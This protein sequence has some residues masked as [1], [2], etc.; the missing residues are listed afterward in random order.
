MNKIKN[1]KLPQKIPFKFE[2]GRIVVNTSII[3]GM[4][5]ATSLLATHASFYSKPFSEFLH[6]LQNNG[7]QEGWSVIAMSATVYLVL[8]LMLIF[9]VRQQAIGKA[10]LQLLQPEFK[11]LEVWGT[12]HVIYRSMYD[13]IVNRLKYMNKT[14]F[15]VSGMALLSILQA[16][17]TIG[18]LYVL[19]HDDIFKS[20]DF[21]GIPLSEKN[22][23]AGIVVGVLYFLNSLPN[24]FVAESHKARMIS[25]GMA[26]FIG[27]VMGST[28]ANTAFG[29]GLYFFTGVIIVIIRT[30]LLNLLRKYW[31]NRLIDKT[32]LKYDADYALNHWIDIDFNEEGVAIDAETG[33]LGKIEPNIQFR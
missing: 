12:D 23:V 10:R 25:L 3:V 22:L 29:V 17:I 19:R 32:S 27:L 8:T 14:S 7:F 6:F 30:R 5:V 13:Q 33:Q 1:T 20:V 11:K 15:S 28:V 26:V 16:P 31:S 21:L 4:V 9:S 18:L 24:V 2:Y